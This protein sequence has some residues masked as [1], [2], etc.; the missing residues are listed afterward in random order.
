MGTQ[1][2]KCRARHQMGHHEKIKHIQKKK[3]NMQPM[4]G[5]ET[6]NNHQERQLT[7]P[8]IRTNKQMPP[9]Q[10]KTTGA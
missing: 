1:K 4:P 8:P 6:I 10:P 2:E 7:Q 5:R 9:P 3:W